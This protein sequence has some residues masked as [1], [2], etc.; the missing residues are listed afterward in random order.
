MTL[1]LEIETEAISCLRGVTS[2][3]S[4]YNE[5]LTRA[6]EVPSFFQKIGYW[7]TDSLKLTRPGVGYSP[8]TSI[9]ASSGFTVMDNIKSALTG[10]CA[11]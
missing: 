2:M 3:A 8:N 10:N 7:I 4:R 11:A 5:E 9:E 6:F 1:N